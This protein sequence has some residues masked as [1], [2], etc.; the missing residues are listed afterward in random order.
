M[1]RLTRATS[2]GILISSVLLAGPAARATGDAKASTPAAAT[3]ALPIDLRND[4]RRLW[5]DQVTYTRNFIIS[6][7]AGLPDL[8]AVTEQLLRNQDDIGAAMKLIYGQEAGRKLTVLLHN[9][10]Q[11]AADVVKAA[12][13]HDGKAGEASQRRWRGNADDIAAL[14]AGTNPHWNKQTL[15]DM[16]YKHLDLTTYEV[17]SR[18]RMDWRADIQAYA[19]GQEQI[20]MFADMLS[21][22][23][24]KQ[25]TPKVAPVSPR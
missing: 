20:Q 11:I 25:H 9:H 21:D 8:P 22:G 14:L 13:A 10:V 24:I 3:T 6:S 18:V 17:T 16:L 12:K 4:M 23:I 2:F 7:I 5:E 1:K 19:S 15:T